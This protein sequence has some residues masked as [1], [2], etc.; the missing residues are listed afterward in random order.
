MAKTRQQKVEIVARLEE[1]L[2]K[3]TSVFVHFTKVTVAEE[4][5]MRQNLRKEGVRYFVAKK[6]LIKRAVEGLGLSTEGLALSG[7]TAVAAGEGSDTTLPARLMHEVG[8]KL[9]G[10]IAIMGGVFEGKIA[11][12]KLMLEI[13]TIPGMEVLR[14]MFANVVNSP[15]ARFAVALSEVAKTKV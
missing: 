12:Q 13:A 3:G 1:A 5:A 14:G 9:D 8:K 6:S 10:R 11:A 7:E 2:K 4:T 15:R